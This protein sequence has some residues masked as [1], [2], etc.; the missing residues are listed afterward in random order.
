VASWVSGQGTPSSEAGRVI[1]ARP[2]EIDEL[3]TT[4]GLSRIAAGAFQV[5]EANVSAGR[6]GA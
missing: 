4:L 1:W 5:L 3:P 2:D 6:S